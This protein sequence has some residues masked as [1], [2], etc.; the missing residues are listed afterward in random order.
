MNSYIEA[1]KSWQFV[2]KFA[3][4]CQRMETGWNLFMIG[5]IKLNDI[6]PEGSIVTREFY[7]GFLLRLRIWLP[8]ERA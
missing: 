5:F 8:I 2:F 1:K 6:P 7:S 3:R 4:D